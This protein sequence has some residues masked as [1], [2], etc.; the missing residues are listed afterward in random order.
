MPVIRRGSTYLDVST[1][2]HTPEGR[3]RLDKLCAG[4]KL[5]QQHGEW[6]FYF[7]SDMP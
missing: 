6:R 3:L 2:A 1:T 7:D 5:A 4:R